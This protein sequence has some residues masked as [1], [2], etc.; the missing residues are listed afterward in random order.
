MYVG[1]PKNACHDQRD[2][3][4]THVSTLAGMEAGAE[5]KIAFRVPIGSETPGIGECSRVEHSRE[6]SEVDRLP[7]RKSLRTRSALSEHGSRLAISNDDR[8]VG[9]EPQGFPHISPQGSLI[10]CVRGLSCFV[11]FLWS[12]QELINDFGCSSA[13]GIDCAD[14]QT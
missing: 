7:S 11:Q 5:V 1:Q 14:D 12:P 9:I 10:T 6:C 3:D 8:I 2:L 4:S 13:R